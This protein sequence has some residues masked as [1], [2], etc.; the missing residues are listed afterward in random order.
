MIHYYDKQLKINNINLKALISRL[1]VEINTNNL[2]EVYQ[3][4][5]QIY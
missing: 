3:Q 5:D 4:Y 1:D 2:P